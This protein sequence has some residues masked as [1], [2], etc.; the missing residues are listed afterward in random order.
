MGKH[1]MS[2]LGVGPKDD[3]KTANYKLDLKSTQC[4]ETKY[5]QEALISFKFD[6]PLKADDKITIFTTEVSEQK[7]W[8]P[9]D[10]E[11][12]KAILEK[13]IP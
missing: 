8:A 11:G 5:I 6:S 2:V 9:N 7:Q 4:C 10:K 13:K 1:F 3:Y 12:L